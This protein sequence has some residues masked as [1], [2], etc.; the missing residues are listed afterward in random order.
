MWYLCPMTNRKQYNKKVS[1]YLTEM[2]SDQTISYN[3][4]RYKIIARVKKVKDPK[5]DSPYADFKFVVEVTHV[6]KKRFVYDKDGF[7][8]KDASGNAL[9]EYVKCGKPCRSD[10]NSLNNNLRWHARDLINNYVKFFG[11][12][13][14]SISQGTIE[15]PKN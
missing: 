5:S 11:L 8:V 13:Y 12:Y 9:H 6:E 2:A 3:N 1:K 7:R 4:Y 15:W 10:I 14:G